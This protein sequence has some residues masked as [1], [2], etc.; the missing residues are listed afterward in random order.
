ML[1]YA[2]FVLFENRGMYTVNE[3]QTIELFPQLRKDI[4]K[5]ALGS[6]FAQVA[7][8]VSQEDSPDPELLSLTLNCLY[9]ISQLDLAESR[10]KAV[11]ELR[12]A[13]L[14]GYYPDLHGC[15]R[16]N[17]P[18]PDRFNIVEG[19]LECAGCKDSNDDGLRLPLTP[20]AVDAIRYVCSCDAKKM[21]AFYAGEET[22]N[23]L[24]QISESYLATQLERGFSTLDFYKSLRIQG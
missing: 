9:A 10:V 1:V 21:F 8:I 23:C 11:F 24:E 13:C 14:T 17:H 6:Y 18:F 19:R 3:A 5:L 4:Q 12:C 2:E 20:G 16:C 22:L 7:D 15:Y